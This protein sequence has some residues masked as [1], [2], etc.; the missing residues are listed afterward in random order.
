LR[1]A[2]RI[3]ALAAFGPTLAAHDDLRLEFVCTIEARA[4]RGTAR[5]LAKLDAPMLGPLNGLHV[6]LE[7]DLGIDAAGRI[8]G[9][10][11]ILQRFESHCTL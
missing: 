3:E 1:S 6:E 10:E 7:V 8:S 4:M 11:A 5:R 2:L 9:V